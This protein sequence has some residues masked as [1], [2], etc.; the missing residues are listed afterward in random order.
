MMSFRPAFEIGLWNAWLFLIWLVIQNIVIRLA[1]K[2][3][4]QRAGH[5][6]EMKTSCEHRIAGH[7]SMPLWLSAT[8]YSVFLPFQL[9]TAWFYIGLAV[10]LIGLSINLI[11]TIN[12]LTAP[13]NKPVTKGIYRYS[14]HPVYL[15]IFL[16]YLSIGLASAS[17]IFLL[18][19][20]IW[21]I[22]MR[23]AVSDEE[24]YCL[25]KYGRAYS[26]YMNKTQRWIGL[27]R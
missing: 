27:P 20:A 4:Y 8:V 24:R 6:S 18:V 7:I 12:F 5:P 3:I 16:I 26:E 9:G 23:F 25:E 22:L 13:M 15:A 17:W 2:E 11:A 14:R 19:S 1:S 10:F 21:L